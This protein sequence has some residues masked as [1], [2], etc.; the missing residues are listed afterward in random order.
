QPRGHRA[1]G[2][3][4]GRG[5]VGSGMVGELSVENVARVLT[6][7]VP[8]YKRITPVY[9][10]MLLRSL[11]ELWD[12]SHR[13]VLDVGGGTGVM[14][15][16][17]KQLFAV[18]VTSVDVEDRFLTS[19]TVATKTFDGARLPFPDGSFDAVVL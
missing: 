19:L 8:L 13:R 3:T 11:G 17:I 16:A 7:H 6:R 10:T 9:Q 12:E 14:A 2:A 5:S 4:A 15:E 18:E 1:R